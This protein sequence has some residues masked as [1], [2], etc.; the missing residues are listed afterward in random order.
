MTLMSFLQLLY[1]L[2][3]IEIFYLFEDLILLILKLYLLLPAF[4]S[5]SHLTLS[6]VLGSSCLGSIHIHL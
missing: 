2:C 3:F 1:T 6:W 4:A 5:F